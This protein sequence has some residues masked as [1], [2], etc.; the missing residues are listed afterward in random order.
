MLLP[1]EETCITLIAEIFGFNVDIDFNDIKNLTYQFGFSH[2]KPLTQQ[3]NGH[4]T[5][6]EFYI[7]DHINYTIN[8]SN[9][10]I[11]T[12]IHIQFFGFDISKRLKIE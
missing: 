5:Y 3:F 9:Y 12:N 8:D 11:N 7:K 10:T 6:C 1:L 4:V 2:L